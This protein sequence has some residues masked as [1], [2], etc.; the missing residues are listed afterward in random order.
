M[1]TTVKLIFLIKKCEVDKTKYF[2]LCHL[3]S[4]DQTVGILLLQ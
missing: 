1:G 2:F 3:Y 4:V